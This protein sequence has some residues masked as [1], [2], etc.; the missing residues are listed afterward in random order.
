MVAYLI[1]YDTITDENQF[2]K[3]AEAV[4]PLIQKLGGT[5]A[6]GGSPDVLEGTFSWDRA[7]VFEWDSR[8]AALDF[9]HS[10]EYGQIKKLR[11]GIAEF[12]AIVIE[13][14]QLPNLHP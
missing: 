3:Y 14:I 8:Q 11:E 4:E 13:G 9:W 6:A 5:M 12:Q 1:V 2:R 10:P 7:V